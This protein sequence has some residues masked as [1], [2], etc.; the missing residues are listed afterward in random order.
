MHIR[1]EDTE[2]PG[3]PMWRKLCFAVGGVPYQMTT[4]VIGFFL[5]IFLLEVAQVD[6]NYVAIVLFAGKA[7]D[8][9]TDPACGYL[10]QRTR[11][12][13]GQSRPWILFTSPFACV[14]YFFLFYVP[15]EYS[16]HPDQ[17]V[18]PVT[19]ISM[20]GKFAYYFVMFCL[21]EGFLSGLHVPYTTLTMYITRK[22][23]ERDSITAYRMCFEAIGVMA[24]VV[25]QGQLVQ[26]TRCAD[27]DVTK[28]QTVDDMKHQEW[29]YRYGSFI[30]IGLYMLCSCT[31]FFGVREKP[32]EEPDREMSGFFTGLKLV[33]TY[34]PYLKAALTF[35]FLSL[36]IGIVQ[37]NIALYCTH[38]LNMGR[39]F[40]LFI[41]ILL[42]VSIA[43]M[44]VWQYIAMRFG[45]KTAYAAG[46]MLLIP[47]FGSLLYLPEGNIAI[48]SVVVVLS[49]L[50]ISVALLLPWSVLPDVLDMFMLEKRTRKDAIF[51]AFYVF[52]NKLAIGIGL[53][54]SQVALSIGGYKT[55]ECTQPES[56]GR[57]LRLLVTPVPVVCIL[58]ALVCLW[59]Y[60]IDEKRREKIKQDVLLYNERCKSQLEAS[61]KTV[62]YESIPNPSD[63]T[64]F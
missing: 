17:S 32:A 60:P 53:G 35:L 33:F 18:K 4:T 45:K 9:V 29:S 57:T 7:W 30:I 49:G 48:F 51:Y 64:D 39:E 8:A 41:F 61:Q 20:E 26:G 2:E 10:V 38:A 23:K 62:S 14:A 19:D 37:G 63:N 44:P 34:T 59:L 42:A 43:T 52:F 31:V 55:G 40:S 5:N 54:V 25:I 46:M 24:G 16:S 28:K 27:D 47:T 13:W 22:Q 21:F 1:E 36:A 56:V 50:G 6:P 58:I 3:L 15:G 12:R 11:T